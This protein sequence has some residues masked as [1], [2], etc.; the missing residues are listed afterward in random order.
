VVRIPN[1][2]ISLQGNPTIIA[3][4]FKDSDPEITQKDLLN[5][6]RKI[7]LYLKCISNRRISRILF[8]L[9]LCRVSTTSILRESLGIAS[10]DTVTHYIIKAV[11]AGLVEIK[12]ENDSDYPALHEFWKN[13]IRNTHESTKLLLATP[14]LIATFDLLKEYMNGT[15]DQ[16]V[17]QKLSAF[18]KSFDRHMTG[19]A[20]HAAERN[21]KILT[22]ERDIIGACARCSKALT[23][24]HRKSG[25]SKTIAGELYCKPCAAQMFD[26]G[27]ISKLYKRHNGNHGHH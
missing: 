10:R 6:S 1:K 23:T 20:E 7:V 14:E 3:Q 16:K 5:K 22:E 11:N 26:D 8:A 19:K 2:T 24:Q 9:S 12:T 21:H 13:N 27:E 17:R 18:G 15:I 4:L 25:Q